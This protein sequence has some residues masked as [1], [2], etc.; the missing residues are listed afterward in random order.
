MASDLP[1]RRVWRAFRFERAVAAI[2]GAREIRDSIISARSACPI[3]TRSGRLPRS[4][5]RRRRDIPTPYADR[6]TQL[7]HPVA[8]PQHSAPI[9]ASAVLLPEHIHNSAPNGDEL[10]A[11][12]GGKFSPL[13][14][15][16]AASRSQP[17]PKALSLVLPS[18][19]SQLLP[20][21]RRRIRIRR[22]LLI[23]AARR[24][25]LPLRQLRLRR[26]QPRQLQPR[27][28]LQASGDRAPPTTTCTSKISRT[29]ASL[30]GSRVSHRYAAPQ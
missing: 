13:V 1:A 25:Q 23:I 17:W 6:S 27:R 18:S 24:S 22:L 8:A 30:T 28:R 16:A 14:P 26:H 2:G 10:R 12:T 20:L 3:R 19:R 4:P 9:C 15:F 5:T 29:R 7:P 21:W 11:T